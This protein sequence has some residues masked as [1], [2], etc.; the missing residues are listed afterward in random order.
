MLP[1]LPSCLLHCVS[2]ESGT[3]SLIKKTDNWSVHPSMGPY[4]TGVKV[5]DKNP[6]GNKGLSLVCT[7]PATTVVSQS[8]CR[9]LTLGMKYANHHTGTEVHALMSLVVKYL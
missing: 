7:M 5:R 3:H 9:S 8:G 6:K 2:W 1:S 4:F